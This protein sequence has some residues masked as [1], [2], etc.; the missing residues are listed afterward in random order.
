MKNFGKIALGGV[1]LF[2]F[3]ALFSY[4][5]SKA[6]T[7][8]E[9]DEVLE[10][11]LDGNGKKEKIVY[12]ISKD[13]DNLSGLSLY[14]NDSL[15]YN[16][17]PSEYLYYG[18][19]VYITDINPGDKNKEVVVDFNEEF[20]HTFYVFRYKKNKLKLLLKQEYVYWAF[21][22]VSEQKKG[23]NVLMYDEAYCAL[24]NNVPIIKNYKIKKQTLKE[25]KPKDKIYDV[26]SDRWG[27]GD[28]WYTAAKK[29]TVYKSSDGKKTV[30][31]INAGTEFIV[32]KIKYKKNTAVYAEIKIKGETKSAGWINVKYYEGCDWN[33]KLVEN[34]SFAG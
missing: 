22:L 1:F 32:T 29:I 31:T 25:I 33:D 3:L 21:D 10:Y 26:V 16:Y 27:L 6:E 12:Y 19:K 17:A 24:G 9:Q 7:I 8:L 34:P 18:A 11:D 4:L 2:L 20:N 15:A 5:P 28:N 30:K 14:I 13:Y 23:E